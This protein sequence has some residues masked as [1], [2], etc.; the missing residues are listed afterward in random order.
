MTPLRTGGEIDAQC[1]R[2]RMVL[3]HTILALVGSK[4]VRVQC[5]TCGGQHNYRSGGSEAKSEVTR[6]ARPSSTS[7]TREARERPAKVSFEDMI[8]RKVGAGRAYSPKIAFIL[9]E[10]ILHPIFGRGF[11][12]AVRADKV[13]VTFKAGVKTLVHART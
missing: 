4:P 11:V 5:N 2:C 9:D 8:A 7:G 3:A 1:T 13:D 10:V 6:S 12:S